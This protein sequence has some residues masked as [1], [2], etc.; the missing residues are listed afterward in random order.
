MH[1][2]HLRQQRPELV[3]SDFESTFPRSQRTAGP[4]QPDLENVFP[5]EWKSVESY[6]AGD[7]Q[8]KIVQNVKQSTVKTKRSKKSTN[9]RWTPPI[10]RHDV[11]VTLDSNMQE[12]KLLL[13]QKHPVTA[14]G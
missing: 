1:W 5:Q 8:T 4:I 11:E 2:H 6:L 10:Q 3:R 7:N 9:Q 12:M 13:G 14:A